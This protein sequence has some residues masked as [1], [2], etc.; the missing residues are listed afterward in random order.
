MAGGEFL[1]L[2]PTVNVDNTRLAARTNDTPYDVLVTIVDLLVF[3]KCP[4]RTQSNQHLVQSSLPST[5]RHTVSEQN[6]PGSSFAS[7]CRPH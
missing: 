6:L 4:V 7:Y 3:G 1:A 5:G 2:S